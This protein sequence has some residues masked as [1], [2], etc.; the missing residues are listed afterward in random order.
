MSDRLKDVKAVI[1]GAAGAIGMATAAPVITAFTS[2][3]LS[4]IANSS[5]NF[6]PSRED[7]IYKKLSANL[8][9]DVITCSV[10]SPAIE[11]IR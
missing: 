7:G 6:S 3:S 10:V 8:D 2:F 4:D 1:T 9:I 5:N 11:I